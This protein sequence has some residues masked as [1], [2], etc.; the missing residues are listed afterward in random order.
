VNVFGG[1]TPSDADANGIEF[2]KLA[3]YN[4]IPYPYNLTVGQVIVI[5]EK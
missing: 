1:I 5:P 3:E 2:E 4:G